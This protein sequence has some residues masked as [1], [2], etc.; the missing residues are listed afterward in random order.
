MVRYRCTPRRGLYFIRPDEALSQAA[1]A[2]VVAGAGRGQPRLVPL[3]R[4]SDDEV[5]LRGDRDGAG[6][7]DGAVERHARSSDEVARRARAP[8]TTGRRWRTRATSSRWWPASTRSCEERA[9]D[10]DAALLRQRR[11]RGRRAAHLRQHRQ[12]DRAVR[13]EDRARLSVAALLADHRGRVHL[14]RHGEHQR[15]DADRS[16]AARRARAPRL[17]VGA[18]DLARAGAPVVRRPADLPRLVAG[19]AQRRLRHLL[20]DRVEGAHRRARRGRLRSARRSWR[21]TSTRT[22]TAIAGRS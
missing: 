5:D 20:R 15:H 14:R 3:L 12:D 17:L 9:G 4:P 13:R 11:A 8:C 6:A 19:L 1:A 7:D 16:D 10:V 2:G 21:P 18:A 22:R